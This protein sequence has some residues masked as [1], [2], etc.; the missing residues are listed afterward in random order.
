M[1]DDRVQLRYTGDQAT[2][3]TRHGI[4]VEPG[5]TFDA[6][7]AALLSLMRRA[8]V[9]HEAECPAPPCRCGEEPQSQEMEA[10][11]ASEAASDGQD[12]ETKGGR[13][14]GG[15]GRSGTPTVKNGTEEQ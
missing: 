8:D 1:S 7:A 15:R 4:E 6:P 13:R 2:T 5:C 14:S 3:F 12:G 10:P 9:E 11:E